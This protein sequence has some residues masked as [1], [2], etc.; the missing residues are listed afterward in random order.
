MNL[1]EEK[2]V[3][4]RQKDIAI[5]RE[6]VSQ[7]LH[8]STAVSNTHTH[9]YRPVTYDH[10]L[11]SES[12][13]VLWSP[14]KVGLCAAGEGAVFTT[15]ILLIDRPFEITKIMIGKVSNVMLKDICSDFYILIM[16]KQ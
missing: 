12:H 1:N 9:P 8:T 5:K 11:I 7:Y 4:L 10:L 2:Q 15:L 14:L 13:S 3:P 16:L 6:M